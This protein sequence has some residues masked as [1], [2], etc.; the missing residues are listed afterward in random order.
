MLY[1]MREKTWSAI[2]ELGFNMTVYVPYGQKWLAYYK[3]RLS[4]RKDNVFFV[5]KNF[6]KS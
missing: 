2:R 1:G 4:E 3:R 5:L 6:L